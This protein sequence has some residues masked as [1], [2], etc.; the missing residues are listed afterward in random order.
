MATAVVS[1]QVAL[2]LQRR[3]ALNPDQ[4]KGVLKA[5]GRAFGQSSG[6]QWNP[7][8]DGSGVVDA[9][10]AA[11]GT[12]V[13]DGN[14]GL[15]PTDAFARALYPALYGRTPLI[16]KNPLLG[17]LLWNLL[18]WLTLTW[19]TLAWDNIAWD[20]IAWDNIA[21]DNIAWDNIA[22]DNIAWDNI[23]WDN[24]AWDGAHL[25]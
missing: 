13:P 1:G 9:Y 19:N 18:S 11:M 7:A 21:W 12:S 22:W 6:G 23:A 4:V 24:I 10:A 17:G 20:N 5:T 3:P 2:M 15:R 16:W 25:D 14:T 8:A